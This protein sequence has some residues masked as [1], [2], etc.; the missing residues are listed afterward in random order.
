MGIG[1]STQ[2][3]H[4]QAAAARALEGLSPYGVLLPSATAPPEPFVYGPLALAWWQ[5][6]IAMEFAAAV[7]VTAL[8]IG[9]RSWITLAVYSGFPFAVY[10]TT[11]GVNDYSPGLLIASGL[12]VLR[13]RVVL[14]AVLLAAAASLKPYAFAWFIPAVGYGGWP[15]AAALGAVTAALW[16]PLVAWGPESFVRSVRLNESVHPVPANTVNLPFMRWLAAPLTLLS[17]AFRS[18]TQ[19][20]LLGAAAFSTYL[21]FDDWASLG[22]WLAVIPAAG[23]AIEDRWA[24]Q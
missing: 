20:V 7:G 17:L 10:L 9:T 6:G 8:L 23:I 3:D 18:W 5:A 22:Y 12:C 4:A 2:V 24:R 13:T 15:A 16:S 14:G 11:T 19:T 1:Y 21:F